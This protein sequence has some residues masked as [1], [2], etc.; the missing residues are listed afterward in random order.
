MSENKSK[1]KAKRTEQRK[2]TLSLRIEPR[3]KYLIDIAARIQRRNVTNYV[4]QVLENSL[5]DI[6]IS[7]DISLEQANLWDVYDADR[8]IKLAYTYP[9]LLTYDEHILLKIIND[10]F[11]YFKKDEDQCILLD[12]Q[13]K[14]A[15][16]ANIPLLE[17]IDFIKV[18]NHWENLN[19]YVQDKG[20]VDLDFLTRE[21]QS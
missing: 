1:K 3:I 20:I 19:D 6:K 2:D 10:H 18:R 4:E 12:D 8:F 11:Q 17:F 5:Q 13:Q 14:A 21:N 15:Y 16:K 9:I 7:D